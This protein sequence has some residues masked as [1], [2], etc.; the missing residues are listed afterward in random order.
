[1]NLTP[2]CDEK[3]TEVD[4][5]SNA[6]GRNYHLSMA[7]TFPLPEKRTPSLSFKDD[8]NVS[9]V[10]LFSKY[11]YCNCNSFIVL[12]LLVLDYW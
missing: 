4:Y 11:N 3:S 8:S 12:M 1:M 7:H 9:A 6:V 10:Y 2:N 5:C